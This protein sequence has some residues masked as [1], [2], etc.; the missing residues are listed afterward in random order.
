MARRRA[1][2][3]SRG[4]KVASTILMASLDGMVQGAL[5]GQCGMMDACRAVVPSSVVP[6]QMAGLS[7]SML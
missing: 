3:F 6:A 4:T 1:T 7:I 5:D 2:C